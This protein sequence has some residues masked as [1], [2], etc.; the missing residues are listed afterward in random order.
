MHPSA[1]S[2][3]DRVIPLLNAKRLAV[4][5]MVCKIEMRRV[6]CCGSWHCDAWIIKH[7]DITCDARSMQDL[8]FF[9]SCLCRPPLR[10]HPGLFVFGFL[11]TTHRSLQW[12]FLTSTDTHIHHCSYQQNKRDIFSMSRGN[13][14][15]SAPLGTPLD[16]WLRQW[17]LS[18]YAMA[19][20][21]LGC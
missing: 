4:A 2:S 18:A 13:R 10:L 9:Y 19:E 11:F 5:E 15:S 8:G 6:G 3:S 1:G 20:H 7:V 16:S 21:P 14:P 17:A 12:R